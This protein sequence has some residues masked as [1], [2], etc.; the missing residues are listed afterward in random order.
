[1]GIARIGDEIY[2]TM[3]GANQ[4]WRMAAEADEI[5]PLVGS[6]HLARVD[7]TVSDA[8]LAQPVGLATDGQMLYVADSQSNT[9]RLVT[10]GP[11]GQ[12]GTVAGG[13]VLDF[14]DRDGE[15]EAARMQHPQG[16]AWAD[17]ALYVA[18]TYNNKIKRLDPVT[19]RLETYVGSGQA[20][21]VDGDDPTIVRFDGPSDLSAAGGMLYVAD[22]NSHAIRV[23][24]LKTRRVTTLAI[25][26]LDHSAAP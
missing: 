24:D 21:S 16:I 15:A 13:D 4:I 7:G 26:G 20:G 22:T 25:T 5:A 8:A 2:V 18:D 3:A 1:L 12:I 9:V 17:G 23:V 11:D 19:S 14:G 10:L 6:G